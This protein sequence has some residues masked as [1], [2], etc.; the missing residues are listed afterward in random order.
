MQKFLETGL[1]TFFREYSM[2]QEDIYN[3]ICH[4][5]C[6]RKIT[7]AFALCAECEKTYSPSALEWPEWLR[8]LW[9]E[10]QKE[11]RRARWIRKFEVPYEEEPDFQEDYN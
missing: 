6:G 9:S 4:A 5:G 2:T 11:R 8:Y 7:F 1:L 3:H 10:T